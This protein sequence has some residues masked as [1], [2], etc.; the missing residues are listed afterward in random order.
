MGLLTAIRNGAKRWMATRL[1][2]AGWKYFDAFDYVR[3]RDTWLLALD[4]YRDLQ[5][6]ERIIVVACY[7]ATTHYALTD[8][9]ETIRYAGAAHRL[10]GIYEDKRG[11]ASALMLLSGASLK[12]PKQI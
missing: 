3:A 7:V 4:D 12:L 10:A 6:D 2:R 11:S 1:V 5:D 8:Y 9:A